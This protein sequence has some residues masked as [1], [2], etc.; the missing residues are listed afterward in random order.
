MGG[1]RL[2]LSTSQ[3][4]RDRTFVV[5]LT[6]G[7]VPFFRG[8]GQTCTLW[9]TLACYFQAFRGGLQDALED[10]RRTTL[11]KDFANQYTSDVKKWNLDISPVVRVMW[12]PL[13]QHC[14]KQLK[15]AFP[16]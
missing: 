14:T 7:N 1:A 6:A 2:R 10:E 13:F 8:R 4:L 12:A 16:Q 5:N 15:I 9:G 11:V 3:V